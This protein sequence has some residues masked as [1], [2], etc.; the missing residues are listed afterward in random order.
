MIYPD[1]PLLY[2]IFDIIGR[3]MRS[4]G[5][6]PHAGRR[7]TA[8]AREAGFE[9]EELQVG[10]A[11][12]VHSSRPEREFIAT[13]YYERILHSEVGRKAE[14]LGIA[15]REEIENV[16]NAWKQWIDD[17]DGYLGLPSTEI[18]CRKNT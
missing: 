14:V 2:R 17:D 10:A 8:W 4:G 6:E 12:E 1:D 3:V 18:L 9:R 13:R 7:L 16:A 5:S 11:V 15:T